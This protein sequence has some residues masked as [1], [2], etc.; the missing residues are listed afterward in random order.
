MGPAPRLDLEEAMADTR[1]PLRDMAVDLAKLERV[2]A[3]RLGDAAK[4][5]QLAR[6]YLDGVQEFAYDRTTGSGAVPTSLTGERVELLLSVSK[7]LSRLIDARE[8]ECVLRVIPAVAKRLQ[9]ELRSTHEDTIRPFIY[10]WALAGASKGKR[11]L[12]KGVKG[13]PVT[14]GS[15]HQLEAFA[16][17]AERT[18]HR[19]ARDIDETTQQWTLFVAD[20]FDLG[21]YLK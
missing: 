14:F 1:L 3:D 18:G 11:G 2:L 10:S 4:G 15:E 17:E 13:T 20:S 16:V 5:T 6:A 21:P 9:L 19:V 8:I 7:G 12:H